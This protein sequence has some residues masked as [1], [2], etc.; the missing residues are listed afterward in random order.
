MHVLV[1]L[2][3]VSARSSWR[4]LDHAAGHFA[5][6]LARQP[7]GKSRSYTEPGRR[8]V[9]GRVDL[10]LKRRK[11]RRPTENQPKLKQIVRFVCCAGGSERTRPPAAKTDT[12]RLNPGGSHGSILLAAVLARTAHGRSQDG[13][14][15]VHRLDE[16]PP[17][18]KRSEL[19]EINRAAAERPVAVTGSCLTC[20][21]LVKIQPRERWRASTSRSGP[22]MKVWGHRDRRLPHRCSPPSIA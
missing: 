8:D 12:L 21:G 5:H 19:S 2:G 16:M 18:T 14:R 20:G 11:L 6:E 15:G 1:A 9:A 13:V 7:R 3:H 17:I 4:A 22:L 10:L